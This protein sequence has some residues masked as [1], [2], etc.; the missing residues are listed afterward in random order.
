MITE[1]EVFIQK[2]RDSL[3]RAIAIENMKIESLLTV[4]AAKAQAANERLAKTGTAN[5]V[6]SNING[7]GRDYDELIQSIERKNT[8]QQ[9]ID[10]V[11]TCNTTTV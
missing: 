5:V 2:N 9:M 6:D 4:I 8:F 7:I 11:F 10:Y 1:K 3:E